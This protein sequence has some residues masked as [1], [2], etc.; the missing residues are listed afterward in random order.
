MHHGIGHMVTW[1][2]DT[3]GGGVTRGICPP[4]KADPFTQEGRPPSPQGRQTPGRQRAS[5]YGQCAGGTHPTGMHSCL[6]NYLLLICR[7]MAPS[8]P[9]IFRLSNQDASKPP[10]SQEEDIGRASSVRIMT[11]EFGQGNRDFVAVPYSS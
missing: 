1:E 6:N 4:G 8:S 9:S 5:E 3:G 10:T 11:M 2:G 7:K